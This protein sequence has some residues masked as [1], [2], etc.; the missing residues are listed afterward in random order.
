M[1]KT[2]ATRAI[3]VVVCVAAI[4]VGAT[5]MSTGTP[6]INSHAGPSVAGGLLR[7]GSTTTM[8]TGMATGTEHGSSSQTKIKTS[9]TSLVGSGTAASDLKT[10]TIVVDDDELID[11]LLSVKPK[12]GSS[13]YCKKNTGYNCGAVFPP[14]G[15]TCDQKGCCCTQDNG[16]GL[17]LNSCDSAKGY[18][19]RGCD[20]CW[21]RDAC[22]KTNNINV[23]TSSCHGKSSCWHVSDSTIDNNSCHGDNACYT[24]EDS[25]IGGGSCLADKACT[26]VSTSTIHDYSCNGF[27]PCGN[28]KNSIIGKGSCS[29]TDGYSCAESENVKIGNNSCNGKEVCY[30]CKHNVPDNACNQDIGDTK[31]GYCR[32]CG[33]NPFL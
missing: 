14:D 24:V 29:S 6:S 3:V 8:E 22:F 13:A 9:S 11:G 4:V 7:E 2:L 1:T 19:Y 5:Y 26:G 33:K 17:K 12:G 23:G 21:G 28:V 30:A 18:A 20:S 32:Y 31:D 25:T 10:L 27:F 16:T 15:D